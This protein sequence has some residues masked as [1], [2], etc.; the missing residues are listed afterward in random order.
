VIDTRCEHSYNDPSAENFDISG[1][2]CRM[3]T[4]SAIEEA[5]N[6]M[7]KKN[8]EPVLVQRIFYRLFHVHQL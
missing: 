2:F 8:N 1:Y 4:G 5:I 6:K 3:L 7:H